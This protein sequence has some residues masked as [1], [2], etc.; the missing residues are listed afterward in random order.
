MAQEIGIPRKLPP[1]ND[2]PIPSESPRHNVLEILAHANDELLVE[3]EL[4][5]SNVERGGFKGTQQI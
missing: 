3:Q 5:S 4:S 1:P 2:N